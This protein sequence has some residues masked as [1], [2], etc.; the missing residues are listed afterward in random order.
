MDSLICLYILLHQTGESQRTAATKENRTSPASQSLEDCAGHGVQ[1][2]T[3]F[4][5]V[6]RFV[7]R[8]SRPALRALGPRN[9]RG[10][11]SF[12]I[13]KVR[14]GVVAMFM[15]HLNGRQRLK[16]CRSYG[17]FRECILQDFKRSGTG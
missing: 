3:I 1:H 4:C 7:S 2:F 10:E 6:R 15:Y 11:W 13:E 17:S 9:C 14:E 5:R 12:D 16:E 8:F